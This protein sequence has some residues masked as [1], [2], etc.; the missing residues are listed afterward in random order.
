MKESKVEITFKSSHFSFPL[1]L[2]ILRFTGNIAYSKIKTE[3]NRVTIYT[4]LEKN[5]KLLALRQLFGYLNFY[6]ILTVETTY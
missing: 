3:K 2:R 5:A 1:F 4:S 6:D